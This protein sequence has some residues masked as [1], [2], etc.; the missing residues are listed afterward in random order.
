MSN[1]WKIL[2]ILL[3]LGALSALF[4]IPTTPE[5]TQTTRTKVVTTNFPA[6]DF[7]RT[8]S[9][10]TDTDIQ[11]LVKPGV[12][13]HSYEPTPQDIIDVQNS[14]I[15]IYNGG[16][17]E[18]W[19]SQI[20]DSI[21]QNDTIIIRM[22][23]SVQ[24]I[25]DEDGYDEHIWT[26][27]VNVSTISEDIAQAFIYREPN[28]TAIIQRNLDTF[29]AQL[30]EL[31]QDFHELA[32]TKTGTLIVADRFP[33]R[34]FIE[35]YQ[36]DYLA[37][38]PG[39]SEQ[40]EAS[41]KTIAKLTKAAKKNKKKIIFELELSNSKIAKTIAKNSKSKI[42]TWHSVHNLTKEDFE[43]G[44]TY[45]DFMRENLTNLSEALSDAPTGQ[46]S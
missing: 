37:A 3:G 4:F 7:A 12:D 31:D 24:L 11:L 36:F 41:S 19:V 2:L 8:I 9:A 45:L 42:L 39:C 22:M 34:Y 33:F 32:R 15:F 43:S 16:E 35:A 10:E 6:Y 25:P 46:E 27:P 13:L 23:D 5:T 20:L 1:I 14:D 17:S 44:K 38:F 21:D 28:N 18:E 40:T 29:K 30:E 26:S